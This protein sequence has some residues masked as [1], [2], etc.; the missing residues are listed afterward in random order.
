MMKN[1]VE[2]PGAFCS[3]KSRKLS[4]K[5]FR[6]VINELIGAYLATLALIPL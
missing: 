3:S 2:S 6:G 5:S 1:K 4:N